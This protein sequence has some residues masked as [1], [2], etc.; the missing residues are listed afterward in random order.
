MAWL[1]VGNAEGVILRADEKAIPA[2][3]HIPLLPGVVGYQLPAL[4]AVVTPMYR[5]DWIIL[6]TD[7]IRGDLLSGWVGKRSPQEFARRICSEYSKGTD[8]ALVLVARYVGSGCRVNL[9]RP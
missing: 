2:Q 7:G 4:R 9:S 8:D 6:H 5:G 3:E 1:G